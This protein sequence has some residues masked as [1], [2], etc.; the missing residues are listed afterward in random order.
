MESY[1][2]GE[3]LIAD[4]CRYSRDDYAT[5]LNNNVLVVGGSGTGKTRTIV[6]P[7]MLGCTG[8]QIICAPKGGFCQKYGERL[9]E[10]GHRVKYVDFTHPK[11]RCGT[12]PLSG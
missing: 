12:I 1:E 9:R 11:D 6:V 10:M 8:S 4:G 5:K 3:L 2:Q 7:N